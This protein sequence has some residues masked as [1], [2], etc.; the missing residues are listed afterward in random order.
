M[1]TDNE[2]P[3]ENGESEELNKSP[4]LDEPED[5]ESDD[6]FLQL[7]NEVHDT[8]PVIS[9]P[10][11]VEFLR[12]YVCKNRPVLIRGALEEWPLFKQEERRWT[13]A[14]LRK[15]VGDCDITVAITPN[16]YADA[17]VNETLFVLPEERKMKF[18]NFLDFFDKEEP[19]L[20][21]Y[22]VQHQNSNFISE[23]QALWADVPSDIDFATEAL[24]AKPDAVNFWMGDD[25][26]VTSLHK[27]HYENLYAV[28]AGQKHFTLY[29][30]TDYPFLYER[31]F[32]SGTY[33]TK[34]SGEMGIVIDVPHKEVPW[35]AVDPLL[36]N[37]QRYPLFQYAS[38]I[39]VT[40][41]A[42]DLFYLPSMFF[43][44][45]QQKGDEEGRTIAVNYWYD[46]DFDLKYAYFR[47]LEKMSKQYQEANVES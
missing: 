31:S 25:R 2:T 39:E 14:Y 9:K 5:G 41:N 15:M 6:P 18:S 16:G 11:P 10:S 3:H 44:H 30:P 45:V 34:P 46:M 21:A 1:Q 40:V 20:E 29:P 8:V 19:T 43:H 36:P 24:G 37:Y 38:P 28:I 4:D 13:N 27:D 33:K 47:F 12:E 17:V 42:G 23:F 32:I 26:S 22:Y 35:I 7:S